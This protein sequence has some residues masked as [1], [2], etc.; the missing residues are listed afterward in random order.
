MSNEEGEVE[1][2]ERRQMKNLLSLRDMYAESVMTPRVNVN[3]LSL[4][5]TVN[6][7]CT[8]MMDKPHS[9]MPVHGETTDDVD[10][11]LTFREAF[12]LKAE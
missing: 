6:E 3:F 12:K 11:V 5:M 7:V 10:F 4:D 1:D 9:R 2:T 8:F